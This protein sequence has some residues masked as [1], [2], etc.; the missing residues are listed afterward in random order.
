ML[1]EYLEKLRSYILLC[2]KKSMKYLSLDEIKAIELD[3]LVNFDEYCKKQGLYYTL[4]GGT[5]LGAVR[6]KGFIPWDDDID[7]MM[8]RSDYNKLIEK[9]KKQ[10][11]NQYISLLAPGDQDYYYPFVKIYNCKTIAKMEDN[12]SK[13]GIWIDIF[14]LD[15]LPEDNK[16]LKKLFSHTRFWRAVVISMTTELGAEKNTK[17]KVAKFFL[18]LFANIYGKSNVVRKANEIS[19]QY[20]SSIT[21]FIGGALWGYGPGER[22]RKDLYLSPCIVEFEKFDF[23]APKC[24]DEYLKGLYGNY[25]ELPPIEKRQTHHL[26]AWKCESK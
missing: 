12:N 4:A 25:M 5:L 2:E 7:V 6:H 1:A 17:K 16:S 26:K 21:P 3:I 9:E 23:I 13:H 15:N 11:I 8:P 24:W 20:N 18:K 10:K 19:Q 14:P 22:L